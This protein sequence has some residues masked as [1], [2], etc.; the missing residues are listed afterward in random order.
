MRE[1]TFSKERK[2]ELL[3]KYP[4]LKTLEVKVWDW[5]WIDLQDKHGGR[6]TIH[7]V[8][9]SKFAALTKR[10]Q[11]I[12]IAYPT[13]ACGYDD[14]FWNGIDQPNNWEHFDEM[15]RKWENEKKENE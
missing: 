5:E 6:I 3:E 2:L 15:L 7:N 1:D 8:E 10:Q 9:L 14:G 11:E 4:A 13:V 12:L